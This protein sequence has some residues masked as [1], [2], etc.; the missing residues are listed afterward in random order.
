MS[1]LLINAQKTAKELWEA[2]LP[3]AQKGRCKIAG[4][5]RRQKQE[6]KDIEILIIPENINKFAIYMYENF[7]TPVKREARMLK[8]H[9]KGMPV[10]M[11]IPQE[12]DW[13]RIF[14]IRTGS[15]TYVMKHVAAAWRKI[16]WVG[17][18]DGLR[19]R[20]EC[21]ETVTGTGDKKKSTWKIKKSVTNPSLPPVWN[22]E[23]EFFMWID[24]PFVKPELRF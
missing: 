11:F 15:D 13:F 18:K 22:S 19:K 9:Y 3:F 14:A 2:L 16:G 12:H 20:I 7:H 5:I 4:S 1:H 10:D 24:E 23:E 17:T 6:I 21:D 8:F